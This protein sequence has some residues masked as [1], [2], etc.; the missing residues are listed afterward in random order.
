[1]ILSGHKKRSE[2]PPKSRDREG[3]LAR[4]PGIRLLALT[5]PRI[6]VHDARVAL[7]APQ[8]GLLTAPG[9]ETGADCQRDDCGSVIAPSQS[10]S[11]TRKTHLITVEKALKNA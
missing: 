8:G 5:S 7:E 11:S 10:A 9:G 1:L 2:E 6:I 3:S 4:L